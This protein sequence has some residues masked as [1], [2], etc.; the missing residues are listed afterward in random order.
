MTDIVGARIFG[1]DAKAELEKLLNQADEKQKME[2]VKGLLYLNHSGVADQ[3][4]QV[5]AVVPSEMFELQVV[6]GIQQ[7]KSWYGD[8]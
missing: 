4:E 3:V 6:V 2:K 5:V 7:L 1:F 8:E